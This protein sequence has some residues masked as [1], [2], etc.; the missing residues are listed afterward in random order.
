MKAP[1]TGLTSR[2]DF[3]TLVSSLDWVKM[4]PPSSKERVLT[5]CYERT[6]GVREVVARTGDAAST[7]IGVSEGLL[8]VSTITATGSTMMFTAVPSGSWVG[9][10]SVIKWEP[11]RY[12]LL[13]MRETRV[14][15]VPRPT[16][17]WLLETNFSF[18]RY[19]IDHL[20][21]RTGQ[22]LAMLEIGRITDP[23]GRIA[24]TLHNL[25]NSTLNPMASPVVHMSQEELGELAGLSR[26][27]TNAAISKLRKMGLIATSY[28]G[29]IVLNLHELSAFVREI[30][31]HDG[32]R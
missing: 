17:M 9:E 10:G 3:Q 29:V 15:H 19:I 28:A 32:V 21:E 11:R 23:T 27:S 5:D 25:F 26:S 4:L 31:V 12:D 22:F 13:A 7:W 30:G 20:N 24:G 18:C 2:A 16:L 1:F 14:I 8:K 6:Y